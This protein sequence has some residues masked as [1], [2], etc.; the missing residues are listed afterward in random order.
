MQHVAEAPRRGN[1]ALRR[2]AAAQGAVDLADPLHQ[3]DVA[4]RLQHTLGEGGDAVEVARRP[5]VS[6][7]G[8]QDQVE[9]ALGQLVGKMHSREDEALRLGAAPPRLI[10][11]QFDHV[12]G[13]QA[14]AA[15]HQPLGQHARR[16]ADLQAAPVAQLRQRRQRGSVLVGLVGASDKVPRMRTPCRA[17]RDG[18]VSAEMRLVMAHS[19][20]MR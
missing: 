20:T 7:L 13:E 6:D 1:E 19:E 4:D 11:R 10:W 15:P 9:A 16:A 5:V 14:V 2:L 8:Q 3:H 17:Q 12:D 18:L